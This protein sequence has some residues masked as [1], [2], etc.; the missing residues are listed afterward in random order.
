VFGY[1][2]AKA[3]SKPNFSHSLIIN[4]EL[5]VVKGGRQRFRLHK[6]VFVGFAILEL[7]KLLMYEFHYGYIKE[8]YGDRAKL[9]FTDTD[10]LTYHI[11]TENLYA[12][13]QLDFKKF[14]DTSHFDPSH[15]LYNEE[16]RKV[17]GMFKV[18]TESAA[19]IQYVGL[20]AKLYSLLVT[21]GTGDVEEQVKN[22]VKGFQKPM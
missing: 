9:L 15:F 4:N 3:V 20:R 16:N 21:K 2:T 11:E 17:V 14:F 13:M 10:S 18:E 7:S 6:P 12:D 8:T 22:P 19:P 1:S 5:I